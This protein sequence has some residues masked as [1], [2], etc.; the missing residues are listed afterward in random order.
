METAMKEDSSLYFFLKNVVTNWPCL[1][2]DI[3]LQMAAVNS[4]AE[5]IHGE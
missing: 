2:T 5:V 3:K 1:F 4:N